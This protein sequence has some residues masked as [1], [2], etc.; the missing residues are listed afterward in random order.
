MNGIVPKACV[1]KLAEREFKESTAIDQLN[2]EM[3]L[4]GDNPVLCV[5]RSSRQSTASVDM[6]MVRGP[7]TINNM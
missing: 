2:E 1:D 3:L 6:A 4:N 7:T 5:G